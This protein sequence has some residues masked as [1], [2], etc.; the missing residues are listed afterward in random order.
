MSTKTPNYGLTRLDPGD[1]LATDSYGFISSNIDTIDRVMKLGRDH[2]HSGA[3]GSRPDPDIAA[4]LVLDSTTGNLPAGVTVRYRYTYVDE[5]GAETAGAPEATV[6]TPAPV[7]VPAGS[8]LS[9][10]DTG[11]T[12]VGGQYHY[13][14]TAYVS[15]NTQ[16]TSIGIRRSIAVPYAS[17]LNIVTV[18]FP[19]LPTFA[20][21]FN[22]YRR[23]P[24]EPQYSYL[25]SVDMTVATPPTF[26]DDDGTV[27]GNP[28]RIPPNSNLTFG[29]NNVTVILPGATPVVPASVTWKVYRT[30]VSGNWSTSNL[31]HVVEETFDGSGIIDPEFVDLGFGTGLEIIPEISEIVPQPPKV[32]ME[33]GAEVSGNLPPG[34]VVVPHEVT[35]TVAGV[36]TVAPGTF[37][38]RCPFDF[39]EIVEVCATLGIGFTPNLTDVI[40]DVNKYDSIAATPAWSTVYLTQA[41][42]PKVLVGAQI[43]A[44]T[45]PD[46]VSLV[47]GDMLSMDIDQAGD[48]TGTDHDMTVTI[49]MN[50]R[51]GSSTV[52][53]FLQ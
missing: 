51:S 19:T 2:E 16:E 20:D 21:G 35:F 26:Y 37:T 32:V 49:Y 3:A 4:T 12:L 39:G 30:Y 50:I 27:A 44:A 36:L 17:A 23:A 11:G 29:S 38:W 45:V 43:G 48:G 31:H 28:G 18:T 8:V 15:V 6:T 9:N 53:P 14:L 52:T 34:L 42:R 7:T 40:V 33:D 13:A 5:F 10:A 47:K 22:I 46:V 1:N 24:G 41:N 25:A